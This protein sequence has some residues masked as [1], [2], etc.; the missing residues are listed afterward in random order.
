MTPAA[1]SCAKLILFRASGSIF[2]VTATDC[3]TTCLGPTCA[4]RSGGGDG[5]SGIEYETWEPEPGET[6]AVLGDDP[7]LL[8]DDPTDPLLRDEDPTRLPS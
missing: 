7:D 4:V 5:E 1:N 8:G 2:R 6:G 3:P